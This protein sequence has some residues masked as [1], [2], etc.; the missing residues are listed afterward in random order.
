[1]QVGSRKAEGVRLPFCL[2]G[3][4]GGCRLSPVFFFSLQLPLGVCVVSAG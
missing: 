1:M 4:S 2:L 3:W